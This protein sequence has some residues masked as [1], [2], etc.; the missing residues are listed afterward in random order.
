MDDAFARDLSGDFCPAPSDAAEALRPL[1]FPVAFC[2]RP[3][4]FG[5]HADLT[6]GCCPRCGWTPRRRRRKLAAD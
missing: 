1:L 2:S 6:G 4:P 3:R 5:I